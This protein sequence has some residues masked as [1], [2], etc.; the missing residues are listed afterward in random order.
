LKPNAVAGTV[1]QG[2]ATRLTTAAAPG[3]ARPGSR[4][5]VTG[6][7]IALTTQLQVADRPVTQQGLGGPKTAAIRAGSQRVVQ[8]KTYFIGLLRTK[9]NELTNEINRLRAE[10][11]S[12]TQDQASY[13]SYEKRAESLAQ[14]LKELQA[15]LGDCN[16]LVDKLNTDSNISDMQMDYSDSK[17]QNDRETAHLE[18]L[19]EQKQQREALIKQLDIEL[20]QERSLTETMV[21]GMPEEMKKKYHELKDLNEHLLKQ[22]ESGQQELDKL[23]MKKAELEEELSMSPVKQ[24]AVRLYEQLRELEEKR[25]SLLQEVQAKGTPQEEKERLLKQVKEDNTEI[26]SMERQ[27]NDLKE[28]L[29]SL[30][31]EL[32]QL[33]MDID[34]NQGEKSKQFKELKRR[35]ETID[36]FL[37]TFE[38]NKRQEIERIGQLETNIVHQL[39]SISRNLQRTGQLPTPQELSQMKDDLAF[40]QNEMQKSEATASGLAGENA[41]LQMD[42]QKIDQLELKITQEMQ[43]LNEKIEKMTSELEVYRDLDKLKA[44]AEAK[45]KKLA[46]DKQI[47]NRRRDVLKR[48]MQQLGAQYEALKIQLSENETYVQ[49]S[50]LE[51][52]WQHNEQNNFVVKEFIAAKT[53]ETDYRQTSKKVSAMV[54]EYNQFLI[55]Q[56][57]GKSKR[58]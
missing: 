23:N 4:A 26:A 12:V 43:M 37:S 10:I 45:K 17:A 46:E 40:K 32:R 29:N 34:E 22:L 58:G 6:G 52:K 33:D 9:V 36:E 11:D 16:T 49:L 51:R 48:T 2:T 21:T 24:E 28:K 54:A 7:G 1:P 31:E 19:F 53:C 55:D 8:D 18:A 35:E 41:K 14:E 13:V 20:K 47:L 50:N 39:E 15:E 27:A 5:G 3:T 42:L 30:Q 25:D 38:D 56:L 44:E 57:S